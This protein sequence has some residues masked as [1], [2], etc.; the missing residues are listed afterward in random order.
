MLSEENPAG[1]RLIP[2]DTH[3]KSFEHYDENHL[4]DVIEEAGDIKDEEKWTETLIENFTMEDYEDW[5]EYA[6]DQREEVLT[7]M[8]AYQTY[9]QIAE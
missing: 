8:P 1:A 5:L 2:K 4:Y 9:D 6:E 3:A 7:N